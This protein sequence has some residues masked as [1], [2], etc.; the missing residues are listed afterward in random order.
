M[1][2]EQVKENIRKQGKTLTQVAEEKGLPYR[3]VQALLNG[4]NKGHYGK[5]HDV[6]IALGLKEVA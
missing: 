2:P 3:T 1:T 6:A 4:T 5:A